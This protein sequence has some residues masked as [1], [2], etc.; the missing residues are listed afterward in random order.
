MSTQQLLTIEEQERAAYLAGDLRAADL[1]ARAADLQEQL[2]AVEFDAADNTYSDLA[3]WEREN[4]DADLYKGFF[5]DC[6]RLLAGRYPGP[7]ISSAY[8]KDVIFDMIEKG[9]ICD[10]NGT[11]E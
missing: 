5:F 6:F 9:V 2:D 3:D 8:D 11:P 1:F 7:N 4:G 10:A